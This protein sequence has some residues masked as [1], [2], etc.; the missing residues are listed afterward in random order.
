MGKQIHIEGFDVSE[1]E[2]DLRSWGFYSARVLKIGE[3]QFDKKRAVVIQIHSTNLDIVTLSSLRKL[4]QHVQTEEIFVINEN[5]QGK[6][7]VVVT[8]AI[9]PLCWRV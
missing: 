3:A 4:A 8:D 9:I 6:Y 7:N 1:M 2:S 5:V